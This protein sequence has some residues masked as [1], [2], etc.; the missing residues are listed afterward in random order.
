[1]DAI[2]LIEDRATSQTRWRFYRDTSKRLFK[3]W[4]P[5]AELIVPR[6]I[7]DLGGFKLLI[8]NRHGGAM[9]SCAFGIDT[10]EREEAGDS[11]GR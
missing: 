11:L 7:A 6:R 3:G 2:D 9:E 1:M 8:T 4:R 10:L 5:I